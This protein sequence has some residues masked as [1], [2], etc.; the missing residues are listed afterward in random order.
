MTISTKETRVYL[1]R[2]AAHIYF[3]AGCEEISD[4][5]GQRV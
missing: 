3:H 4:K 2:A 1:I 5:G